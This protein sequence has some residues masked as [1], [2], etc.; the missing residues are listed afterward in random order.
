M[1]TTNQVLTTPA[2]HQVAV[3]DALEFIAKKNGRTMEEAVEA[4][5]MGVES[6]V[7]QVKQLVL[8][9]AEIIAEEINS[10]E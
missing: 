2:Y 5:S 9:G 1:I 10:A 6:V 3:I 8:A 4:F 7:S